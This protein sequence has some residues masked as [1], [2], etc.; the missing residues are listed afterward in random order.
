MVHVLIAVADVGSGVQLEEALNQAGFEA[1]W[2]GA[3]ADGPRRG[4]P[5]EV[6]ILDADHLGG[7]LAEVANTWRD[8]PAVPGVIAVGTS[9]AAREHAPAARV[10]LLSP[11][12]STATLVAAIRDAAKL[13]L[14]SGM[15]WAV[16]R[17]ARSPCRRSRTR[18]TRGRRRCST[19]ATSTSRSRGPR[20]AGTSRT[21]RR[22][23]RCSISCA[24]SGFRARA[25]DDRRIFDGTRTVQSLVK[26]G[27]LDPTQTARLL[28]ALTS[29]GAITLTAEVRDVATPSRR[30]LDEIRRRPARARA[31]RL[32]RS[33]Y[34]DVLE[35]TPLAEY[36]EIEAGYQL[37][38]S[39]Y[40]PQALQRYDLGEQVALVTPTWELVEKARNVL[41]DDVRRAAATWTISASTSPR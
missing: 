28:W 21:T 23:P 40:S 19:R 10:T 6:V 36:A 16:M 13:R 38:G 4:A 12:A 1:R 31:A 20:C 33:T 17:A 2:D 34:F 29:L 24:R 3:Q 8:H 37:V 30:S 27:P 35:I 14:A 32:E 26:A 5:C 15:S 22:R 18:S 39:R 7:R 41:V 11:A 9:A 25:R